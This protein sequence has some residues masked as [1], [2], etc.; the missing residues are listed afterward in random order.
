MINSW[1]LGRH[2]HGRQPVAPLAPKAPPNTKDA[3]LEC[4]TVLS[5]V[6]QKKG[7]RASSGPNCEKAK[8]WNM[9]STDAPLRIAPTSCRLPT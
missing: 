6:S 1:N 4:S 8:P 2:F 3:S 5:R 9:T 7:C